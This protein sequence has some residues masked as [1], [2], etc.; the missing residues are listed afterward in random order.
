MRPPF[1]SLTETHFRVF[2]TITMGIGIRDAWKARPATKQNEFSVHSESTTFRERNAVEPLLE[3][4]DE[5][6]RPALRYLE[7]DFSPVP[8]GR[9]EDQRRGTSA[10]DNGTGEIQV[11][12]SEET[13]GAPESWHVNDDM[14]G[15]RLRPVEEEK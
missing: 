8:Q 10:F 4:S 6:R 3:H 1:Y 12:R 14:L 11:L 7:D 13:R 2:I 15:G 5:E 9:R